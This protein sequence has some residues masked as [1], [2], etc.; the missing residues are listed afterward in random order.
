VIDRVTVACCPVRIT[1]SDSYNLESPLIVSDPNVPA[2]LITGP[3]ADRTF[4]GCGEVDG[5]PIVGPGPDGTSDF[6]TGIK[7]DNVV[8]VTVAECTI[9]GFAQGIEL[10][11][12]R[13]ITF[14]RNVVVRNR[15]D[16]IDVNNSNDN[17]FLQNFVVSNLGDG[18]SLERTSMVFMTNSN[19]LRFNTLCGNGGLNFREIGAVNAPVTNTV[20]M[21]NIGGSMDDPRCGP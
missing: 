9:I 15:T 19:A 13:A 11:N 10:V 1:E 7:L 8:F 3:G 14:R 4:F 18:I 2:I 5:G 21:G 6:S 12:S 16:G 17:E 20:L